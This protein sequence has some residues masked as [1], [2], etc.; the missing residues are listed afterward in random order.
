MNSSVGWCRRRE[1]WLRSKSAGKLRREDEAD[2][3]ARIVAVASISLASYLVIFQS[4]GFGTQFC[5]A[6]SCAWISYM[7]WSPTDHIIHD[8]SHVLKWGTS[9]WCESLPIGPIASFIQSRLLHNHDLCVYLF[10]CNTYQRTLILHP[11]S[12]SSEWLQF[13]NCCPPGSI[14][15]LI[16]R[17]NLWKTLCVCKTGRS[18]FGGDC[19]FRSILPGTLFSQTWP[20]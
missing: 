11:R 4:R 13:S 6:F 1:T 18:L 16:G 3:S 2:T 20:L 8:P 17:T 15:T 7:N 10:G 12:G 19:L 5:G 9:L 14:V